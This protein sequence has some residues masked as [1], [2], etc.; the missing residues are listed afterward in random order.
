MPRSRLYTYATDMNAR[1][2]NH[3]YCAQEQVEIPKERFCVR[4]G[5]LPGQVCIPFIHMFRP[6]IHRQREDRDRQICIPKTEKGESW[7]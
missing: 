2:G 3:S 1:Q 5:V 4:I 6:R 7:R